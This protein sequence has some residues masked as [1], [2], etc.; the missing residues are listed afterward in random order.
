MC[1][2]IFRDL[3]VEIEL[4]SPDH[5]LKIKETLTR[6][7]IASRKSNILYQS[8]HILHKQGRY[9]IMHFK[10]MFILD[11]KED[12]L[13]V[14]DIARRNTIVRLLCEWNLCT[15]VQEFEQD[16]EFAKLNQIKILTYSEKDQWELESKYSMG[17]TSR[18]EIL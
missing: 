17:K 11:G 5:F 12:T 14:E 15:I 8:C 2:N 13:S 3:G 7:G 4:P 9:A 1:E 18:K 6:M 16:D 10:E